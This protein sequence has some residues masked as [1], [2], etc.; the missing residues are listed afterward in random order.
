MICHHA[1]S[2]DPEHSGAASGL[3]SEHT[4]M[5]RLMGVPGMWSLMDVPQHILGNQTHSFITYI[6]VE[7]A[8][9]MEDNIL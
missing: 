7:I 2:H 5:G 8:E 3:G 1:G 4:C 6:L 9:S